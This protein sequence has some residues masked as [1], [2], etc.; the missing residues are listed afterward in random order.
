[1]NEFMKIAIEEARKGIKKGDGGP[2]GSVIVKD[3]K[4]IAVAHNEVRRNQDATCHGEIQAIRKASRKLKT[5][6]L[7]GCE[8]YTTAEPCNMCLSACIWAKISKICYGATVADTGKLGYIDAELSKIFG[9]R[10]NLKD[11]LICI[12]REECLKLFEE[13]KTIDNR[14]MY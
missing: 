2:F 1:M 13:F 6:D 10:E 12:D 4:I 3:G 5:R 8:L 11:K 14:P 9:G 7:S